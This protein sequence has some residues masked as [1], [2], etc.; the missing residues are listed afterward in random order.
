MRGICIA[1]AACLAAGPALGGVETSVATETYAVTGN[2]GE[3]LLDA[4]DRKGPRYGLLARAMAQTRY[5]VDWRYD[6]ERSGSRCRLKSVDASLSIVYRY[7]EL[8]RPAPPELGRRW[9]KFIAGVRHHEE[10]HGQ[11]ARQMVFAAHKSISKLTRGSDR[12]ASATRRVERIIDTVYAEYEARQTRF[13][14]RE[15]G[16]GGNVDRLLDMLTRK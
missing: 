8:A 11:V 13:D 3:A 1:L 15:H 14:D 4:M 2:S 10:M 5:K 6:W 12:C 7:P 16:E 9:Q